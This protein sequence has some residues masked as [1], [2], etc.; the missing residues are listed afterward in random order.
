VT[1]PPGIAPRPSGPRAILFVSLA[2]SGFA[3]NSLLCREALRSGDAI[4]PVSFSTLRLVSGAAMLWLLS[5]VGKRPRLMPIGRRWFSSLS[6]FVYVVAFSVAYVRLSAATGALL[7]FGAVQ[8]TMLTAALLQGERPTRRS[9]AG[10]I[11]AL[12]GILSLLLP[13]TTAPSVHGASA[14][15]LAGVAWGLYSLASF[16]AK[17]PLVSTARDFILVV[18]FALGLSLLS[19][20]SAFV[21]LRGLLLAAASGAFASALGYAIWVR[22]LRELDAT[23][24]AVVQL[25]VPV[26]AGLGGVLF[27]G[28]ALSFRTLLSGGMILL[29]IAL[30]VSS[31]AWGTSPPSPASTRVVSPHS[32]LGNAYGRGVSR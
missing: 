32:P 13:G 18:P 4:D 17:D 12:A 1:S 25:A 30:V 6:L 31:G 2:L 3:A 14:M 7:L 15:L 9:G 5:V 19:W 26:M 22:A 21:S 23:T 29:G 20:S 8:L 11:F 28:E 24:A 16:G 10:M 27:L